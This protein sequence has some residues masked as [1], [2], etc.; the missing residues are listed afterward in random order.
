MSLDLVLNCFL[1][2]KMA[3]FPPFFH[4]FGSCFKL[5]FGI[6]NGFFFPFLS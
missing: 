3:F 1:A 6:K 5:F 4:E 2:L